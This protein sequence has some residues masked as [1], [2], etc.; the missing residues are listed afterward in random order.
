MQFRAAG[1][2][3]L[4]STHGLKQLPHSVSEPVRCFRQTAVSPANRHGRQR[5]KEPCGTDRHDTSDVQ[6]RGPL[7]LVQMPVLDEQ[8]VNQPARMP[9][10]QQRAERNRT[11]IRKQR[12]QRREHRGDDPEAPAPPESALVGPADHVHARHE[13]DRGSQRMAASRR[14]CASRRSRRRSMRR[15]P[16]IAATPAAST[17]PAPISAPNRVACATVTA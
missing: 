9:P 15:L 12:A 1:A 13:V 3:T 8:P 4:L 6:C 10:V 2:R 5:R 16:P 17:A 11:R 14:A 7:R